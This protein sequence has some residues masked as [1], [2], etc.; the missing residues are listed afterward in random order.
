MPY[1]IEVKARDGSIAEE[2]Y[3]T[4]EF[5]IVA[6]F[7][8]RFAPEIKGSTIAHALHN[9]GSQ[10]YSHSYNGGMARVYWSKS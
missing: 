7:R 4:S 10:S 3:D 9:W 5:R 1:R 8:I 2:H 6:Y